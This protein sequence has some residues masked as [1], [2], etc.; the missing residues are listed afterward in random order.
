MV[1]NAI[2]T[3][4]IFLRNATV[5]LRVMDYPCGL[6]RPVQRTIQDK[7]MSFRWFPV[8]VWLLCS[9]AFVCFLGIVEITISFLDGV[10]LLLDVFFIV[11]LI[12]YVKIHS[13]YS[14]Q[15]ARIPLRVCATAV[16]FSKQRRF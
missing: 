3:T 9:V 15:K 12:L 2:I 11:H 10:I 16:K 6:W 1:V 8:Q 4:I 5:S 13:F 14:R 7:C